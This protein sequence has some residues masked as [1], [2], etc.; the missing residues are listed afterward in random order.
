MAD[1]IYLLSLKSRH[2]VHGTRTLPSLAV[3][4]PISTSPRARA[5]GLVD[6]STKTAVPDF[7]AVLGNNLSV[8]P[9]R[10]IAGNLPVETDG[11]GRP[12][13]Q[14]VTALAEVVPAHARRCPSAFQ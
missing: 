11:R 2:G 6:L 3:A 10:T 14:P 13:S 9:G 12:Y 8:E 4:R 7:R 1:T 5:D